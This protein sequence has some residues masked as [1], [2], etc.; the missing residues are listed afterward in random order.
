MEQEPIES[1]RSPPCGFAQAAMTGLSSMTAS[2]G[3]VKLA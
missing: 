3:P 2:C 1:L